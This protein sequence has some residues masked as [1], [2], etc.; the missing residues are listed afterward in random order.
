MSHIETGVHDAVPSSLQRFRLGLWLL[1]LANAVFVLGDALLNEHRF[2][3]LLEL[4]LVQAAVIAAALVRLRRPMGRRAAVA[5]VL[6]VVVLCTA[7]IALSGI[8]AHEVLGTAILGITGMMIAGTL[9][10]WGAAAQLMAATAIVVAVVANGYAVTGGLEIVVGYAGLAVL[11]GLVASVWVAWEL[12][13]HRA[14]LSAENATLQRSREALRRLAAIVES[15]N[16]AIIGKTPDGTILSWNPAAERI[17]GYTATEMIGRS[18]FVIVP[19]DRTEELSQMLARTRQGERIE[20]Y[21]TVRVCKDGRRIDVSLTL[22]PIKDERGAITGV[23]TIAR[24]I[25]LRKRTAA[26][27]AL[28]TARLEAVLESATEVAIIATDLRGTIT[29]FNSGAER[30]LG[31]AAGEMVGHCTPE[32]FHDPGEIAQH[33]AA[34]GA[35]LG[36]PVSGFDVFV[37]RAR[38]GGHEAREWT[39]VCNDGRRLTVDL[40]VTALRDEAGQLIGF[41]GVAADITGRKQIEEQ[42]RASQQFLQSTLDALS[43]HVAILDDSGEIVA[44]NQ[45]WHRFGRANGCTDAAS[46]LHRNYLSVCDAAAPECPE[47][48]A[49]AQGIRDVL[50]G[51]APTF[52]AEYPCHAPGERRW[53]IVRVTRFA[54]GPARVVV[55]HEDI[56]WRKFAEEQLALARDQA[57]AATQLKSDFIATMSHEIRTP[58]NGVIG[59]TELLLDTPLTPQQRGYTE[60]VRSSGELLLGIVNDILDFSKIEAGKLGLELV[61]FD[62]RQTVDELIGLLADAARRKGL[63][64]SAFI[65]RNVPVQL[66]GDSI[67]LRQ[68]LTNLI[69]NAIKFTER[70]EI[71]VRMTLARENAHSV[72]IR[73]E[74][75]DTGIGIAADVQP[76]L[77]DAFTQ[78]DASTTRR[79][80][81]TGLGL[82]ITKQLVA[83]MGGEV[84]AERAPGRGSTFWFTVRLQK[85]AEQ[86][87]TPEADGG[88]PERIHAPAPVAGVA[89][90]VEPAAGPS[91]TGPAPRLLVVE[92]NATNREVTAHLVEKLGYGVDVAAGGAEAL[93]MLARADYAAVLMD[94]RMPD[95]DGFEATRRI[96]RRERGGDRHTPVIALTA[97]A[98]AGYR[99]RCLAAG[100]DDYLRKPVR[101]ED[102]AATLARWVSGGEHD[103]P[104]AT[105]RP[106]DAQEVVRRLGG[107]PVVVRKVIE[108]F[109]TD[110]PRLLAAVHA[111]IARR[112]AAA[113][114][115][116][117]HTLKGAVANF[118]A[119]TAVDAAER[120]EA[121]GRAGDLV[122]AAQACAALEAEL[123]R[124]R[125]ALERLQQD[126]AAAPRQPA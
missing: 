50:A 60:T 113:L 62:L 5:L 59:M 126:C 26:A 43:A 116:A 45:A 13:R 53:F 81:G 4:K 56:T 21:E 78:A 46:G 61:D 111:A 112:D 38:R 28:A 99:Q 44:V 48:A 82:A 89:S 14:A 105:D 15:S 32:A 110:A 79:Y 91:R 64:L 74:V 55:A 93:D 49:V 58:L 39:Y 12:D 30:M 122:S 119:A 90:G 66:R 33:A 36:H 71:I 107:D 83:L 67:R 117:A 22:S 19:P 84:G 9:F 31:F 108:T 106:F 3:P 25:T 75:T 102:L 11:I 85:Q 18:I 88:R 20:H 27:L 29:V 37:E 1:L 42:M 24:D 109:L 95:M 40:A 114:E 52:Y 73:G 16:D 80:G 41:L 77:F 100:M 6:G 2:L 94:C 121:L 125:P 47:A 103:R 123:A 54:T 72:L 10:P 118:V 104:A 34:L 35:E 51:R 23:S 97:S 8:L 92:D 17:Y 70:G 7:L 96:R 57:L 124:L 101:L 98:M 120:V 87:A 115:L 68:V 65:D 86:H 76:R 63:E 69:S